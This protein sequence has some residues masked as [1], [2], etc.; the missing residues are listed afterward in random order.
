[1]IL[2][3][4]SV[5]AMIT[6]ADCSEGGDGAF[7]R[8]ARGILFRTWRTVQQLEKQHSNRKHAYTD[9][10]SEAYYDA[11]P[12]CVRMLAQKPLEQR[13]GEPTEPH[14]KR[15]PPGKNFL[16]MRGKKRVPM[17]DGVDYLSI[18]NE[19]YPDGSAHPDEHFVSEVQHELLKMLLPKN[20][21]MDSHTFL[22]MRG[23]KRLGSEAAF[24]YGVESEVS[25]KRV[26]APNSFMGMRGKR[27][28][29][30]SDV[31]TGYI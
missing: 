16:G 31:V 17:H 8:H 19:D 22:G 23:K 30:R 7:A 11:R 9:D 12:S 20:K 6:I 4:I 28:G 21:K 1:M 15:T 14:L 26:P 27:A 2:V 29:R 3:A 25:K 18:G 13:Y 10:S 5:L 24:Y